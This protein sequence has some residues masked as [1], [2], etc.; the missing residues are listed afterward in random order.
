MTNSNNPES[1]LFNFVVTVIISVGKRLN[2]L[3]KTESRTLSYEGNNSGDK[4][5]PK[6]LEIPQ[7]TEEYTGGEFN[8]VTLLN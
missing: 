7:K 3:H 5:N 2:Y 4:N 8:R 1:V 6:R